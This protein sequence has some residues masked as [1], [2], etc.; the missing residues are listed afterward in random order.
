M[1]VT[2][3][4]EG[5]DIGQTAITASTTWIRP[6]SVGTVETAS[7]L[8][9]TFRPTLTPKRANADPSVEDTTPRLLQVSFD[10]R[11]CP[12]AIEATGTGGVE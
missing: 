6:N 7:S 9:R 4:G 10:D 1:D 5:L 8:P 12:H 3:L 11:E 2:R